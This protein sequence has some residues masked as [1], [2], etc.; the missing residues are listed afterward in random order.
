MMRDDEKVF[1]YRNEFPGLAQTVYGQKLIYLDNAATNQVGGSVMDA[2]TDH[3][4]RENANTHRGI[5][6]LGKQATK[7]FEQTRLDMAAFI[8]A[9][10][11][12][13]VVFDSGTTAGINMIALGLE[14]GLGAGDA[15]LVT[16]MEH[17]SNYLPWQQLCRRTGAS[18][19]V[20]PL[21]GQGDIDLEA[22]DLHLADG[23]V[24]VAAIAHTSNVTGAV[25][26]IRE[27]TARAHE[28]GAI[29]VVD[30]AQ[31]MRGDAVDV[32]DIG[33]DFFC[34]SAHKMIGPAGIGVIYGKREAFQRLSISAFGGGMVDGVGHEASTFS[35]L[36]F[37]FEAGTPNIVG[38]AGLGAA[39]A[40]LNRIGRPWIAQR[41]RE[42]TAYLENGLRGIEG[43]TVLGSPPVRCGAVSFVVKD[44]HAYDLASVMDK[45]GV[46]VRAG[47]HCAIP[48]LAH[49]GRDA[50]L[51][52]SPAFYNLYEEIDEA[53][54]VMQKAI[55]FF[56]K[57]DS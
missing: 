12:D 16:Q 52:M 26:P 40:A 22:Y 36:P 6:Y 55:A 9:H 20:T 49:F 34:F 15:V 32:T 17:H 45:H 33:C 5:H 37:R 38:V 57:W 24:K 11:S 23:R 7:H 44:R 2:M 31:G 43:V 21:T 10:D 27:M 4:L 14:R 30:G 39:A 53:L 29:C 41:E 8:G 42:L 46:A 13:C 25:N 54:I 3:M 56:S 1:E 19:R 47:H 48:C 28:R 51:R 18:F 50:V 35:D